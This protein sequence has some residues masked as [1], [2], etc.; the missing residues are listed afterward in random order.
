MMYDAVVV[1]VGGVGSFALRALAKQQPAGH[2][3]GIERFVVAAAAHG[4]RGSSHG[5]TRIYRR[6]YFEHPSYVPWI[7]YSLSV[8]RELEQTYNLSLMQE[9]GCL[10]IQPGTPSASLSSATRRKNNNDSSIEQQRHH[11][12]PLL[13][14]SFESAQQHGIPVEFISSTDLPVRYP[15]FQYSFDDMKKNELGYVGLLEPNA[16]FL[17]PELCQE[18]ALRE[19]KES[20][21]SSSSSS[22]TILEN[23]QVLSF[24]EIPGSS[25]SS[26]TH[27]ELRIQSLDDGLMLSSSPAEIITTK[28]LL[29]S[30]GAW[31]GQLLPAWA[32]YLRVIRQLQGWVDVS[33]GGGGGESDHTRGMYSYHNMPAWVLDTPAWNKPLYGVPCDSDDVHFQHWLKVGIH[34]RNDVV[35][36]PTLNPLEISNAETQELHQVTA[37]ALN[38]RQLLST[39]NDGLMKFVD[40]KPCMYTMTPDIHY[41]IGVPDGYTNVFAVAGLS[42]HGFKMTPALGQMMADFCREKDLSDWK[43]EF[44]SPRRFKAY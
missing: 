33:G 40:I 16:G 20:L 35:Q 36:N 28:R 38:Q 25:P 7:E 14:A 12:P 21:S 11:M 41:M 10:L 27:I 24:Q 22:V 43:L 31:T 19:A 17:R 42:G 32:P 37:T 29:L 39:Q 1:G 8:F 15:Q 13:R 18:A 44:C 4:G 3:L 9:C 2:F 6:A 34:G 26:S 30:M 23:T 5:K